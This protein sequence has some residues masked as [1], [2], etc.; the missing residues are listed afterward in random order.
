[1]EFRNALVKAIHICGDRAVDPILLY[2]ALCDTVGNNLQLKPQAASFHHFD[3]ICQIVESMAKDP[4]PRMIV[5]LFE[6]C[7]KQPNAPEKLCLRWIHTVFEIYYCAKHRGEGETEQV[8]KSI[9]PYK[10]H[11][12]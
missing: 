8:L 10:A 6:K 2:Y 12:E 11:V 4:N 3:Q 1:M 7:K 9:E 5:T